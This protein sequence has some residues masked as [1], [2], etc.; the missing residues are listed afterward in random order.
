MHALSG[1]LIALLLVS[2]AR[3]EETNVTTSKTEKATLAAGC[4]WCVEAVFEQLPGVRKVT[5][6]YTGGTVPNPTYRQVCEGDTGH[7]EAAEIE[8]DPAVLGYAKLLEI[9]GHAHDPTQLNRQGN[10]VGTQYRSAVFY[11]SE[12]QRRVA[13]VWKKKLGESGEYAAPIVT[14]IAPAGVFYPAED[15]HQEYYRQHREQPYCR[16][17]IR[18]KLQKLGLQE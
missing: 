8:F 3:G 7:A 13:E 9:F 15:Y 6:G 14:E 17:V 16:F 12:E 4:F 10:D 1:M 18:P 11:H 2:A 5:S